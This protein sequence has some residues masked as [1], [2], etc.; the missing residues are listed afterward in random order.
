[1]F[2]SLRRT[3]ALPNAMSQT[4]KSL[5]DDYL[6]IKSK[7]LEGVPLDDLKPLSVETK[8]L[9]AATSYRPSMVCRLYMA[10][11]RKTPKEAFTFS[12]TV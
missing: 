7:I 10:K 4:L 3:E 11:K 6:K 1:M 12:V 8:K 2:L 9:T 5:E